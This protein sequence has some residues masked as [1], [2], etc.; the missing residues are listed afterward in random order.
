MN[1]LV[2]APLWVLL[3]GWL[4]V[5][6]AA[7]VLGHLFASRVVRRHERDEV[8][9]LANPMMPAL[10]AL[11]A[12]LTAITLSSEAGYLKSAQDGVSQEAA[13]ASKLAWAATNPNVDAPPIHA[14]L[15]RYLV[16]TRTNEWSGEDAANGDD[17][18][19]GDAL[20]DLEH[21]VRTA[22]A[23]PS[24][25]TPASSELLASVDEISTGRRS[26]LADASRDLPPLYIVTLIASG[27]A[28]VANAGAIVSAVSRRSALLVAGL[29]VVVALSLAL[30]CALTGP[31]RGDLAVSGE[32]IDAVIDDLRTGFFTRS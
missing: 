27:L 15:E 30:L 31:F 22:A 19:T 9:G 21:T 1:W 2:S 29:T 13:S 20:A 18:A 14:S 10:G 11:F 3:V 4:A 12:V 16:A 5:T 8:R 32:P 28:L 17:P 23:A 24:I 7:A 25:G 26:R 6:I